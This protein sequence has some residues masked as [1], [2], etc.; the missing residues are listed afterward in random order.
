MRR[1]RTFVVV[2]AL[3]GAVFPAAPAAAEVSWR[4]GASDIRDAITYANSRAGNGSFALVDTEGNTHRH[5][6]KTTVPAA[7]VLKVMF[8]AAY[9]RHPSVRDRDLNDN[10]RALLRP[11]ITRSD[12]TSA[13]RIA[14]FVGPRA[15][16]RLANRADMRDFDYT[17][18]WGLTRTSARDQARFMFRLKRYIPN[19]HE[20]YAM[21]LLT[22]IVDSQRW[23]IGT[24]RTTGWKKHFKGG[25]GSG[26][27]AVDH[28][29]VR[30][31]RRS[32]ARIGIAVMTTGSPSHDYA[33][34]T[35]RGVFRR[36]LRDLPD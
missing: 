7:S 33:K 13:S 36:L 3:V 15:M 4:P 23:G 24:V 25:W 6:M 10:D 12:N 8:M 11:M 29:V 31:Q 35:L 2:L 27:G 5:H 18:P 17:R 34:Q 19:R 21:H 28:Q 14:D 16:N 1:M 26:S 32:G 30:L 20:G 9:L 22:Q